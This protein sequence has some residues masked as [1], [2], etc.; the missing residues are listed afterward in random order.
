MSTHL[1][2]IFLLG[3]QVL[4]L[5]P[6]LSAPARALQHNSI[7]ALLAH[8]A[9]DVPEQLLV[10]CSE[11]LVH[12]D[13]VAVGVARLAKAVHVELSNEGAEVAVL[14]ISR[15]DLFGEFSDLLYVEALAAGGP[16]YHI[17]NLGVLSERKP[18][19]TIYSSLLMK[20]GT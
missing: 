3:P 19:S 10:S 13:V 8:S 17:G 15:K 5:A 18:T 9:V 1:F 12:V 2:Y 4:N 20:S 11:V 7:L 16:P 6:P 14:K